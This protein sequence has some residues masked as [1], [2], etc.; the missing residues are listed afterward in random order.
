MK[1]V[2]SKD[3]FIPALEDLLRKRKTILVRG[4]MTTTKSNVRILELRAIAR[5]KGVFI[6]DIIQGKA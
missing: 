6:D 5:R 4:R 2:P 1:Y 3:V